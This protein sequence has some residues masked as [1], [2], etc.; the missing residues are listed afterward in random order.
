MRQE[1]YLCY[2]QRLRRRCVHASVDVQHSLVKLKAWRK[3]LTAQRTCLHFLRVWLP[4]V[5]LGFGA[6]IYWLEEI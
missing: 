1:A 3:Y 6:L 2:Y 5:W 4:I